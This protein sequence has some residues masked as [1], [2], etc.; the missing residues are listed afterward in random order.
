MSSSSGQE[1]KKGSMPGGLGLG[2]EAVH[3]PAI[4]SRIP[5]LA[6]LEEGKGQGEALVHSQSQKSSW[7]GGDGEAAGLGAGPSTVSTMAITSYF[8]FPRDRTKRFSIDEEDGRQQA[9]SGVKMFPPRRLSSLLSVNPILSKSG[10]AA[11]FEQEKERDKDRH[12]SKW[13]AIFGAVD[14]S[15]S[16]CAGNAEPRPAGP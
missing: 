2:S 9:V 3:L 6:D 13:T 11:M 14:D 15:S 16:V 10:N 5:S 4:S 1:Q 12:K 7:G 8:N